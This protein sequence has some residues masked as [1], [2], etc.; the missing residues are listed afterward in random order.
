MD[1]SK[2]GNTPASY[3]A[4]RSGIRAEEMR[5]LHTIPLFSVHSYSFTGEQIVIS[6]LA[7]APDGDPRAVSVACDPGMSFDFQYPFPNPGAAEVYWYWPGAG[8]S[9]FRLV[10]DLAK[11]RH[12]GDF[13]GFNLVFRGC[14]Q[15]KMEQIRTRIIA[16]KHLGWM[17]NYPKAESLSRVQFYDTIHGAAAKGATDAQSILAIAQHYGFD[18]RKG[19]I[20]DWGVGHG[21]VSRFFRPLGVRSEL[22]G[23]DIDPDNIAWARDHLPEINF[24]HGPQMPPT[25]YEDNSFDLIFGISVMT[26]L[27]QDVR[28]AWLAELKRI[29]RPGGL[30]LLTFAGDSA[31]AFSSRNLSRQWLDE[32]LAVGIGPD[33]P[34]ESL[35]G[36][37]ENPEYYKNTKLNLPGAMRLC[38]EYLKVLGGHPCMFGYQDLVVARKS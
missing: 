29:L 33:L 12:K 11:T 8:T 37:I 9:A 27:P 14:K 2:D 21:R 24:T 38:E 19:R 10:I 15:D 13:Y 26:H 35:I 7:L 31:V 17:E 4:E 32:Y 6:G 5:A 23:I 22:Y 3:M 18:D 28:R 16:P 20:L 36:V 34:S 25:K 1:L 30:A